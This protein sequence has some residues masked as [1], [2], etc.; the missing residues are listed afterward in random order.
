MFP[1]DIIETGYDLL[2]PTSV[3]PRDSVTS[4]QI[5]LPTPSGAASGPVN[6]EPDTFTGQ[7]GKGIGDSLGKLMLVLAIGAVVVLLGPQLL[8]MFA[9]N[10]L[11]AARG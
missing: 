11:R 1:F 6:V 2:K 5:V 9:T 8:A 10:S 3:T 7:L 4:R